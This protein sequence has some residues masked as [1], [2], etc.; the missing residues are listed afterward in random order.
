MSTHVE[1]LKPHEKMPEH[2]STDREPKTKEEKIDAQMEDSFPAAHEDEPVDQRKEPAKTHRHDQIHYGYDDVDLERA[3][4][5]RLQC[6][7]DRGQ[8][9]RAPIP[10]TVP[11]I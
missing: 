10:L 5:R 2:H 8:F 3:E 7:S 1:K 4:G 9:A 6:V 11:E